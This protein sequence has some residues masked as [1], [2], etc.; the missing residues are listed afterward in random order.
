MTLFE[1]ISLLI[2]SN[3][4]DL[5]D[6]TEEPERLVKQVILDMEKQLRE[7]KCQVAVSTTDQH[8][9]EQRLMEYQDKMAEWMHKAELSLDR[10]EEMPARGA[11]E[12]YVSFEQLAGKVEELVLEQKDGVEGLKSLLARLEQKLEEARSKGEILAVRGRR[13]RSLDKAMEAEADAESRL[14]SSAIDQLGQKIEFAAMVS[15][16]RVQISEEDLEK[17]LKKMEKDLQVDSLLADLK[18]RRGLAS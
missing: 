2:R 5:M 8:M 15:R 9:L 10:N 18:R 4:N 14:Q 12:R 1:K 11:L 17:K 3:L 7:L 16:A 6:K 13:A